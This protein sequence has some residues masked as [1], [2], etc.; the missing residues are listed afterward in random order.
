MNGTGEEEFKRYRQR[1][2]E[3]KQGKKKDR[4]RKTYRKIEGYN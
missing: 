4:E 2:S 1:E 3:R